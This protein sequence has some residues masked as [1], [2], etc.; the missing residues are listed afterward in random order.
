[1][2]V[3]VIGGSGYV[4]TL[5]MPALAQAHT[6]TIYDRKPPSVSGV[7]YVEGTLEEVEKLSSAT[8][9]KEAVL[10][11]AMG[12][13]TDWGSTESVVTSFDVSVK[14]LYLTLL[15]AHKA[16]ISHA[17]YTSSMSVYADLGNRYFPDE[18]I[19]PDATEFYGFTKRLGEEVCQNAARE[20]GMSVNALRLCLPRSD[21]RWREEVR[22]GE[23]RIET[24][25]NDVAR[26]LLAAMDRPF[27][28]FEAFMISGDYDYK[29]M[30]MSKAK[31][32]LDWEPLARP[33]K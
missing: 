29:I 25:A 26:A 4:G 21:D 18:G 28:G 7:G 17:V 33:V 15:A 19:T 5:V 27:G 11:M 32:L 31:R 9:G 30:N 24:A 23:K 13:N 2:R 10:F 20:W 3:L 22:A 12:N 16:G 1:M 14:G 8:E 6:I